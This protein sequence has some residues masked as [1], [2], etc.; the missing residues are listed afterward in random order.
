MT[1]KITKSF[2]KND[3]LFYKYCDKE[4]LFEVINAFE[5]FSKNKVLYILHDNDDELFDMVKSLYTIQEAAGGV[6]K[7]ADGKM[8]AIFRRGKWDLPKGKV[9]KGEFYKQTAIREVQEECGLKNLELGKKLSETYHVYTEKGKK[10]LKRTVWFEMTLVGDE[11]PV[12]QTEE[13][14]TDFVWFD[15]QGVR[16]IMKNTYESL[17]DIFISIINS[18]N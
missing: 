18:G 5:S 17:K 15:Y 8:L 10:I 12:V 2:E 11:T 13:D 1:S 6:V 4:E 3:G 16:D 9:E 14:I 7:R